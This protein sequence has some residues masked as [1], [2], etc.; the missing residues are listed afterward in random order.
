[1]YLPIAAI[2]RAL[3][4]F[5]VRARQKVKHRYRNAL[6]SIKTLHQAKRYAGGEDRCLVEEMGGDHEETSSAQ[7]PAAR[8]LEIRS[9][10]GWREIAGQR[11]NPQLHCSA[12]LF[13][14]QTTSS[15]LSM[16]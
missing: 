6:N 5:R 3:S 4:G 2:R 7:C 14:V 13:N 10:S 12:N 9:A 15:F 8:K 1:M 11:A 16:I